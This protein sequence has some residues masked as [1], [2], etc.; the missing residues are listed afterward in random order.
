MHFAELKTV[1]ARFP[2]LRERRLHQRSQGA[3]HQRALSAAAHTGNHTQRADGET[4]SEILQVVHRRALELEP[5]AAVQGATSATRGML[6]RL[7]QAEARR[8]NGV[9]L[10]F[11]QRTLGD[12]LASVH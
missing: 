8:G 9:T 5:I 12:D 3:P 4:D 10:D 2:P 1:L 6:E 11:P 7:A